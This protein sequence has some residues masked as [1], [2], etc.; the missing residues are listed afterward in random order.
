MTS[1]PNANADAYTAA[2]LCGPATI[3]DNSKSTFG[4][5]PA[6]DVAVDARTLQDENFSLRGIGQHLS[7][8]LAGRDTAAIPLS[9]HALTDPMLPPLAPQFVGFFDTVQRGGYTGAKPIALLSSSP[10]TH[11]PLAVAR[12][13]QRGIFRA[14]LVYD[15]IPHDFADRYLPDIGSATEYA[16]RLVWLKDYDH[17]YPISEY[18]SNRLQ[19]LLNVPGER[20]TITGVAVRERLLP[21]TGRE[22]VPLPPQPYFLVT[23]GDDWRKNVECPIVAHARSAVLGYDQ[24]RLLIGGNFSP[25]RQQSLRQL[26]ASIGGRPGLIEFTPH[27]SDEALRLLY[28]QAIATIV[29][30]RV[31]GFSMP[32]IEAAA[33]GCPVIAADCGAQ[34]EL[35]KDSRDRFGADDVMSLQLKLEAFHQRPEVRE[36]ARARQAGISHRFGHRIVSKQFWQDFGLRLQQRV[37]NQ[38]YPTYPIQ[39]APAVLRKIKPHIAFITPLPPSPSGVADFSAATLVELAKLA[40]VS[41]FSN[42]KNPSSPEGGH[43]AI[44]QVSPLPHIAPQHDAVVSVIGN[45]HFHIEIFQQLMRWGGS[46]IAHDARML[47]FYAVLLGEA[48]TIEVASAEL[49]RVVTHHD[50]QMWL[51]DQRNLPAL[52]LDEIARMSNPLMV[53]SPV[54]AK[55]L[56]ARN[57]KAVTLPFSPYRVLPDEALSHLARRQ[58]R[59]SLMIPEGDIIIATFGNVNSDRAIEDC[60]WAVEMLRGWGIQARLAC[61]G[62]VEPALHQYLLSVAASIGMKDSLLLTPNGVSE[63]A[64]RLWLS[65]TDCAVQLRTYKFGGLSGALLDCIAAGIPTVSNMHLAEAMEAPDWVRQVPDEISAVLIAEQLATI[66]AE[67]FHRERPLVARATFVKARSFA[68]YA[69]RLMEALGLG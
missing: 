36:E 53:H 62:P 33:N 10:M 56:S 67:G 19:S 7:S 22:L 44:R 59:Q 45:S 1:E 27:L 47:N 63:H 55:M 43:K 66:I 16:S 39:A 49:G 24:I 29:P 2:S 17:F 13:V 54:T 37:G 8:L 50:L 42:T 31:E 25:Q 68:V 32:I 9:L 57:I 64:Y 38:E 34:A 51:A 4:S 5:S 6:I 46:C 12:L 3:S 14:A 28:A 69:T 65:A 30:S 26:H 11:S 18:T 15:F 20:I 35:L 23:G 58:A 61:I 21:P 60:L 41:V 48:R 52:F 40:E